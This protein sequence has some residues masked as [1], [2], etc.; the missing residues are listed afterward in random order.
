MD[1][2]LRPMK[3]FS[4]LR[5]LGA[6]APLLA[7][8]LACAGD[9]SGGAGGDGD[10]SGDGDTQGD[11]DAPGDGDTQGDGDTSGDGDVPGDGDGDRNT[12]GSSG[13]G[14]TGATGGRANGVGGT[15]ATGG[16]SPSSGP[17]FDEACEG[18]CV[19]K[20]DE[21]AVCEAE[22][23]CS[24][25]AACSRDLVSYCGCDGET[26]EGSSNCA[27]HAFAH[28]GACDEGIAG[29]LNCD[30]SQVVTDDLPPECEYGSLPQVIGGTWGP[31]VPIEECGCETSG[32]QDQCGPEYVC[33]NS[34]RCG[35]LVR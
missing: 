32:G 7:L 35:D 23:I 9:S 22:W 26:F 2:N 5:F 28:R 34:G 27:P 25:Q 31:C 19:P 6:L 12:G 21:A 20:D 29:G 33:Y 30:A 1:D 15:G 13:D 8:P 3:A 4:W 11:G 24:E 14:D 10:T 17:C 16:S 18:S